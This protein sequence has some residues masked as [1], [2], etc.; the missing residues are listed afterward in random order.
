MG[1]YLNPTSKTF[2]ESRQ[3]KIY[4]DKS[5]LI[6]FTNSVIDTEQKYVCVSRP[7]RFG[8]SMALNM[9]SAYYG[10]GEDTQQ[11]FEGLKIEYS[12]SYRLHLNRYDVI[13]VD[14][15]RFLSSTHSVPEMLGK[16]KSYLTFELF[17]KYSDVRYLDKDDFIQVFQDIYAQTTHPFIILIDEWDCL[18][19]EYRNDLEAQ[20]GYLDFLRGWL[21]GKPYVGLAYMTGILPIKKYGSHSALNMFWEYSMTDPAELAEYF[22]FTE[23]ETASLCERYHMSFEETKAWYDGYQFTTF[24]KGVSRSFSIYS[25]KSVVEAMLKGNFRNYWNQTETYEALKI[26]IQMNFDGLKDSVITMLAD[27]CVRINTETFAN[28]M[29]TFSSRDDVL[30]LLVHLGYLT[31]NGQHDTVMIPNKEVGKEYVNAIKSL[32]WD[33]VLQSLEASNEL[34]QALWRMDADTVAAGIDKAHREVSILQYND[35]N[36]LS[37]TIN[38]AFYSAREYYTI[39]REMPAGKGFA[40]ICMVPRRLYS[41]KPAVLIELKWDQSVKGAIS[42]IKNQQYTEA[43]KDYNGNVILAGINYNKKT[44]VHECKIETVRVISD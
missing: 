30:T 23:D 13:S 10:C 36:A 32:G 5:G 19:R 27:G 7:R 8:K 42:Q 34:L 17:E 43:L 40:D 44:K 26:Y 4:V 11:L 14:M 12:S 16:L 3:S 38:L 2:R 35:E 33:E 21:K 37:Y 39:Y 15:Q 25:P 6:E 29:T 24:K 20:K 22:G 1:T 9:L 28:D 18:F 31:Y 41:D